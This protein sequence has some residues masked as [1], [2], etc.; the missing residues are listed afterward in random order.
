MRLLLTCIFVLYHIIIG[1]SQASYNIG[2]VYSDSSLI[3]PLKLK[4]V[5]ARK[6]DAE[7]YVQDIPALLLSKGFLAGSVD[8][9]HYDSA[10]AK[11][12]IFTGLQ[13]RWGNLKVPPE[14]QALVTQLN[15]GRQLH[16]QVIS[17]GQL[18]DLRQRMLDYFAGL[19]HPFA[20]V[21]LDSVTLSGDSLHGTLVVDKGLE[22][23]IDSIHIVGKVKLKPHFIYPYLHL[24]KGMLYNQTLLNAIDKRLNELQFAQPS[25]PWDLTMLGSGSIVN[26][27]LQPKRSNIIN[28]LLG[29][30]PANTDIPGSKLLITGEA[31]ILLRNAFEMGESLGIDWQQI[32]YKSPRLNL[33]YLQPYLFGSQAGVDFAFELFKKDSQFV[34]INFRIGVPYEFT[35]TKSAKVFFQQLST[36]VTFVDTNLIKSSHKLPDLADVSSSN[37]GVEFEW[38]TTD[39]RLNPRKGAEIFLS[40]TAGIKKIKKNSNIAQ[41]VDTQMPDF[42]F[43]SLYDTVKLKTYQVRLKAKAAQYLPI[44]RMAVLKLAANAGWYQSQNYFRNELFQIG[45]YRLLRGF[46]EESIFA[47][48]FATGTAELRYLSGRNSYFFA[49]TD[50][51]YAGYKDQIQSF[52]HSYLGFGLGLALETKNS[53]VNLSWAVGKRNDLPLNLRQSKIHI[54][55]VNFF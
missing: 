21:G 53:L 12:W 25:Q 20:S 30:M 41:L 7:K 43:E 32:Q 50:G 2:Y 13:Y 17:G 4:T 29:V 47:R 9:T 3:K 6:Q 55:F 39:Y 28:A 16:G 14:Y 44:S 18:E 22:Y 46:D 38:N 45:G 24:Q 19:G 15:G 5:F 23:K 49:F 11:I 27:H 54:G 33:S 52:N 37:L 51:G 36:N 40:G 10:M 48:A 35:G 34:N 31:N 1:Y 42:K 8:S 26:V